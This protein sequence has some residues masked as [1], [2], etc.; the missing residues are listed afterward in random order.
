MSG[1]HRVTSQYFGVTPTPESP[2]S[3]PALFEQG[4]V[5]KLLPELGTPELLQTAVANDRDKVFRLLHS[6]LQYNN[7][8]L[9]TFTTNYNQ[10]ELKRAQ[11]EGTIGDQNITITDLQKQIDKLNRALTKTRSTTG[12]GYLAPKTTPAHRSPKHPD[13]PTY[14]GKRENLNV[15]IFKLKSKLS[16]NAD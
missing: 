11:L 12:S 6:K 7:L 4:E 9:S 10:L 3:K 13:T 16:K 5:E 8:N 15:F 1:K 2:S 14:E